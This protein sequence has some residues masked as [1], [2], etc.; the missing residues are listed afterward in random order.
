MCE[1]ASYW[2]P[3]PAEIEAD[4]AIAKRFGARMDAASSQCSVTNGGM[5]R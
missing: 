5:E 1:Q 2:R 4:Y 3:A